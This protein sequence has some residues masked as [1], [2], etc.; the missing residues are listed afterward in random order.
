[1][2]LLLLV[3]MHGILEKNKACVLLYFAQQLVEPILGRAAIHEFAEDFLVGAGELVEVIEALVGLVEVVLIAALVP[4]DLAREALA[5]SFL[6]LD[7]FSFLLQLL[8]CIFHVKLNGVLAHFI[9]ENYLFLAML[10]ISGV[11]IG[12]LLSS[13]GGAGMLVRTLHNWLK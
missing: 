1:M 8:F 5:L 10:L 11:P 3:A 2:L 7:A 9:F 13:G 4:G 6:N 12:T